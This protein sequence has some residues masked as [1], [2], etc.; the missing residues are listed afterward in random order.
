[1]CEPEAIA[2][3]DQLE[4][5]AAEAHHVEV[6]DAACG[7][8]AQVEGLL[9][10]SHRERPGETADAYDEDMDLVRHLHSDR[11]D[12]THVIGTPRL[13]LSRSGSGTHPRAVWSHSF[14]VRFASS[15]STPS[16][17]EWTAIPTG[18]LKALRPKKQ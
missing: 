8:L 4:D 12:R 9:D 17:N 10:G 3:I 16:A 7:V 11:G 13:R 2:D 18:W 5:L 6:A 14:Q 15:G 1:V